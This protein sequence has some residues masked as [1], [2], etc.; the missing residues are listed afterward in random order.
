MGSQFPLRPRFQPP[1]LKF[2]TS[3]FPTVRLQAPGTLQFGTQPSAGPPGLR[4]IAPCARSAPLFAPPFDCHARDSVTRLCVRTPP[5]PRSHSSPEVLAPPRLCCPGF[6]RLPSSTASQEASAP[7]PGIRQ[8]QARSLTFIG[9]S[10]L[11]S[12]P[13]RVS[14]RLSPGL[15]PSVRRG[16][17]TCSS[18]LL[19]HRR[20]PSGRSETLGVLRLS[21]SISFLRRLFSTLY[22]FALA[23]ALLV[24]RPPG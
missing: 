8:L 6:P 10:C 16:P 5:R 12:S 24:A 13:S 20:W 11:S 19:P 22:P 14:L 23:T 9:S 2:R 18:Q 7:L 15:P 3:G 1:S 17:G 21:A 4:P